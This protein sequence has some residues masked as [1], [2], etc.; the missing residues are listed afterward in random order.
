[1]ATN[2]RH[3]SH[4]EDRDIHAHGHMNNPDVAYEER[5]LP[6]RGIVVFFVFL[7]VA[8]LVVHL[9]MWAMYRGFGEVVTRMDPARNPMAK[10]ET[11]PAAGM[12][13]NTSSSDLNKFPQPRLQPDEVTD[14]TKFRL[15]EERILKNSSAWEQNGV[16]HLP[17]DAAIK[18]VAE[19]GLPTRPNASDPSVQDPLMVPSESG[20][21][22]FSASEQ[23]ADATAVPGAPM[24]DRVGES[25]REEEKHIPG[26]DPKEPRN[27]ARGRGD[28]QPA[29]AQK[30][31]APP[32]T[33][34]PQGGQPKPQ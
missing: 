13:Q 19:R 7:F 15:Q 29:G 10:T 25:K 31:S 8:G 22:G 24:G 11:I 34:Q 2:D 30:P 32:P 21:P 1:M 4:G 9:A 28:T 27:P 17:I 3:F 16:V 5:D 26:V 20:F 18:L 23:P 6:A 12:L 14:M 33:T